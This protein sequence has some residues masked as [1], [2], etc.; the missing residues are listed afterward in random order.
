MFFLVLVLVLLVLLLLLLL[1]LI[2]RGD[3]L[4]SWLASLTWR[5]YTFSCI[6]D[7]TYFSL[8]AAHILT[9]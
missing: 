9:V 2:P 5:L 7:H 6:T 8:L 3:T 4:F 1:L